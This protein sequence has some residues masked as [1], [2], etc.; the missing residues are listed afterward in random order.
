MEN[1]IAILIILLVVFVLLYFG[2]H[3]PNIFCKPSYIQIPIPATGEG[4]CK[5]GCYDLYKVTS[6]KL[7][8][9]NPEMPLF[10]CYCDINNCNP[11]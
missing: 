10:V 1:W 5:W 11:Q 4:L 3:I 8:K 7:E 2:E 9:L 6:Y